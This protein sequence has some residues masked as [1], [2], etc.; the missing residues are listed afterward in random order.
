[1][2]DNCFI[3][4]NAAIILILHPRTLLLCKSYIK[5]RYL[6]YSLFLAKFYLIHN[7]ATIAV[8]VYRRCNKVEAA[9]LIID[10]LFY[11]RT[12]L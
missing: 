10:S 4:Y 2:I 7:F 1:M 3:F 11:Q 9:L 5:H 6:F 8:R 12:I